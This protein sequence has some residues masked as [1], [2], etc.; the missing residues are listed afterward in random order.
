MFAGPGT[1]NLGDMSPPR[2]MRAWGAGV[3]GGHL[4][5]G[6]IATVVLH[7]PG[8]EVFFGLCALVTLVLALATAALLR[9]RRGEDDPPSPPSPPDDDP[10]PPWWPEFERRF[11]AYEDERAGT[12]T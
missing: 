10:P 8:A 7:V 12:P 11:R 2:R 3:A 5:L 1:S 9:P 4:V 6:A